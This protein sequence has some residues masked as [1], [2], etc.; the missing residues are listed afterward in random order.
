VTQL[1]AVLQNFITLFLSIIIESLPFVVL[2]VIVSVLVAL[3]VSEDVILKLLPKNRFA[4]HGFFA[5]IGIFLPVCQCGNIPVARRLVMKGFSSSQAMTF[6]LA[7]PIVN[8]ITFLTTYFAFSTNPSVVIIR[9][10]V[11]FLIATVVGISMSYKRDQNSYLTKE[12][13]TICE[14]EH[15]YQRSLS[16]AFTIFQSEFMLIMKM[17]C[18]GAIIAA[19][20]REFL[21][22]SFFL[23]VG[24]SSLLSIFSLLVLGFILS[25]CSTVD[26]FFALSYVTNF[27]LG[28]IVAFLIFAPLVDIEMIALMRTT[29]TTRVIVVVSLAIAIVSI[30]VGYSY[31]LF[32]GI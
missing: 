26:A 31:N 17:L 1:P 12:F 29:F 27:T 18:I 22:Q 21:P 8:P 3:F 23:S 10:V 2:G 15:Q 20:T 5:L 19:A 14:N 6:L 13:K 4:S 24:Q 30:I 28:S 7:A 25:I 9:L 11:A 32:T 16:Y